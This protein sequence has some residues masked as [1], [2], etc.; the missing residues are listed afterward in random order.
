MKTEIE[1]VLDNYTIFCVQHV[2]VCMSEA[3]AI[4]DK[5]RLW[6]LKQFAAGGYCLKGLVAPVSVSY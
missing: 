6:F 2:N 4:Q 1:K 3:A 5:K